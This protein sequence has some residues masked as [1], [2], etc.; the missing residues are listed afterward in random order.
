MRCAVDVCKTLPPIGAADPLPVPVTLDLWQSEPL[1]HG[2][3][4]DASKVHCLTQVDT[5]KSGIQRG[6]LEL[7]H[8][9]AQSLS[10]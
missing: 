5:S 8:A 7:E 9:G 1:T 2:A 4:S 3:I 10:Y 6:V